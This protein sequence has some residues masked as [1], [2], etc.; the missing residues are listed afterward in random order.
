M[1]AVKYDR[2]Y[3]GSD[4]RSCVE[5]NLEIELPM[6]DYVPPAPRIGVSAVRPAST[7]VFYLV[8]AGFIGDWHI[9][10]TRQWLFFLQGEMEY[11]AGDGTI[12]HVGPGSFI[13]TED[14]TGQGHRS[15]VVSQNPTLMAAVQLEP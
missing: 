2:L 5:R 11:E 14:T 3:A 1:S 7:L 13:L 4:G 9:S 12:W 8:P 15:R 6:R 10:P